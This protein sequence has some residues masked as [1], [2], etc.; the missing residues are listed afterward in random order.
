MTADSSAVSARDLMSP[1]SFVVGPD[2][3]IADFASALLERGV[4][5]APVV[6]NS[7]ALVGMASELDLIAKRGET[8]GDVMSRGVV[9]VE[10][11]T[12]IAEI[13]RLMGLHGV[14]RVPVVRDGRLIGS[15]G[16]RDV[17]RHLYGGTG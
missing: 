15:V 17:L 11:T 9:T 14:R 5:G 16:R 3:R 13:V 6:D 2:M 12:G 4:S 8:V 10:E 1:D 7:G